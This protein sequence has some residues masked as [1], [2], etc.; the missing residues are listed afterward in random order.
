MIACENCKYVIV[1]DDGGYNLYKCSL[2][3]IYKNQKDACNKWEEDMEL[4]QKKL[5]E[6]TE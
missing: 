1:E 4:K 2:H 3:K 5:I 6:T